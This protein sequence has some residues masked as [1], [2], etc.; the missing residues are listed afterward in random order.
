MTSCLS[1]ANFLVAINTAPRVQLYS[2]TNVSN[3]GYVQ[4]LYNLCYRE[5]EMPTQ[6][7]SNAGCLNTFFVKGSRLLNVEPPET[8]GQKIN[9]CFC[10]FSLPFSLLFVIILASILGGT[11]GTIEESSRTT[12]QPDPSNLTLSPGFTRVVSFGNAFFCNEVTLEVNGQN[13]SRGARASVYLIRDTPPLTRKSFTRVI[14]NFRSGL[15]RSDYSW[16]YRFYSGTSVITSLYVSSIPYTG[17]FSAFK[18]GSRDQP[19]IGSSAYFFRCTMD[20]RRRFSFQVRNEADYYFVYQRDVSGSSCT[21]PRRGYNN[22]F[23]FRLNITASWT[24]HSTAGLTTAPRCSATTGRQCS[25]HVPADPNYR[26]LIVTDNYLSENIRIRLQCSS[27]RVW[28][29]AVVVLVPLLLVVGITITIVILLVVCCC[30]KKRRASRQSHNTQTTTTEEAATT[31]G[32]QLQRIEHCTAQQPVT[33]HKLTRPGDLANGR[34]E[35]KQ[36]HVLT[37]APP[38][39]YNDSLDYPAQNQTHLLLIVKNNF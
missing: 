24:A 34:D 32:V 35:E 8:I 7:Q 6:R 3:S 2:T 38:P 14:R 30:W 9:M 13:G 19:I 22:P 31:S 23:V 33:D 15:P 21:S 10:V 11:L 5:L 18:S 27:T 16:N 20:Y 29:Y 37:A 12:T 1:N 17:T 28:A 4:Q 25:L 39:S 36:H 26:A